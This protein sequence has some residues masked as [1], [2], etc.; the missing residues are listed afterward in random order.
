M[1]EVLGATIST[2]LGELGLTRLQP[3]PVHPKQDPDAETGMTTP[4]ANTEMMS[5]HLVEISTQV[6]RGATAVLVC[7]G[8]GWHQ[9][10]GA[11]MV[12]DNIVLMHLAPFGPELNPMGKIWNDLR[13]NKLCALVWGSYDDIVNPCKD[14]WSWL[15][16]NPARTISIG[17][18]DLVCVNF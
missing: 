4:D 12:P 2:W 14:A 18:R 5:L 3:R 11:L 6:A 15:I 16:E 10:G 17:T 9:Q 1:V 8:A 13:Q 7:D